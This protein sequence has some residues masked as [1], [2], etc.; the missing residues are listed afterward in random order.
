MNLLS[1][2]LRGCVDWNLSINAELTQYPTV[3]P[4]V[5]VWIETPE[6]LKAV[7]HCQV[8]PYVGVWIE[9]S[10]V[11]VEYFINSH[12]LRGC[13]DWNVIGNG[14]LI[15]IL[16]HTLRGCVDWNSQAKVCSF[17]S[18]GHT[19]RGCVDWNNDEVTTCIDN[20]S[21]PTWVCGLKPLLSFFLR[22]GKVTPY[23]GVWI[24]TTWLARKD[25]GYG[26][27]LRGCVDWNSRTCL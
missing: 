12:T 26:H 10:D 17:L 9:T 6:L 24:E 23:V 13:V 25:V 3:T 21:H 19:L 15:S 22:L 8:T 27:T 2:T 14:S 18:L 11:D 5:G 7:D 1:H 16:C 20:Q 4:Y